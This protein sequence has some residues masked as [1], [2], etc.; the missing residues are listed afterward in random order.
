MNDLIWITLSVF[1]IVLVG[2]WLLYISIK[3]M[4]QK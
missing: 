4:K 1:C 3:D 2:L